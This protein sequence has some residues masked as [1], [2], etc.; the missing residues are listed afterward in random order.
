ML[1]G[2][3]AGAMGYN[4]LTV[5]SIPFLAVAGMVAA[6]KSFGWQSCF[7]ITISH[8]VAFGVAAAVLMFWVLRNLPVFPFSALAP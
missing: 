8:R 3:L 7:G 6:A 2:D 5:L 4:P 1:Y